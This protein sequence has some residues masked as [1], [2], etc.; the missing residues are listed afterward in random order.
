MAVEGIDGCNM[1]RARGQEAGDEVHIP[2]A[3]A[4]WRNVKGKLSDDVI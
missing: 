1:Y 2:R 3:V 4:C